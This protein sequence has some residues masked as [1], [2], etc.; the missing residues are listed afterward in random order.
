VFRKLGHTLI[1]VSLLCATGTHWAM[2]Q[3]V[4]WTTMLADNLRDSSLSEAI[5][6]T[7]DGQHPCCLCKKIAAGK[8]SDK[9]A[10]FTLESKPLEFIS[11][12]DVFV[13]TP[14][15]HFRLVPETIFFMRQLGQEPPTPPPRGLLA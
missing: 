11:K 12:G 2:L 13:F 3:S 8:R 14:P 15:Q 7:F 10:E 6:K 9:K 5:E 1:I 4:A